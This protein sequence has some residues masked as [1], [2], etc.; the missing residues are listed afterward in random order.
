MDYRSLWFPAGETCQIPLY[1]S[2]DGE[3]FRGRVRVQLKD[4]SGTILEERD[5]EV[6]AEGNRSTKAGSY[7]VTVPEGQVFFVCLTLWEGDRPVSENRYLFAT[8]KEAPFEVFRKEKGN[9]ELCQGKAEELPCARKR[10][11][12]KLTNTGSRAVLGARVIAEEEGQLTWCSDNDLILFPGEEKELSVYVV[13]SPK[14][15]FEKPKEQGN[16]EEVKLI[17]EYL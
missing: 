9:V 16:M 17:A 8:R 1:V 14:L 3:A 12:V 6:L 11:P 7:G 13:P 15:P 2:N 4:L 5:F 10:I